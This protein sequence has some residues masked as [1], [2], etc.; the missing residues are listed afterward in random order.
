MLEVNEMAI[1]R[2]LTCWYC[3]RGRHAQCAL[4]RTCACRSCYVVNVEMPTAPGADWARLSVQLVEQ[5]ERWVRVGPFANLVVAGQ[6]AKHLL[7]RKGLVKMVRLE[8]R[9]GGG[10]RPARLLPVAALAREVEK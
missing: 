3:Q 6:W 2:D 8:H 7:K 9:N 1:A 10:W 4:P 5:P